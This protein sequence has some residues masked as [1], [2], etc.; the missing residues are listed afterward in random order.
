MWRLHIPWPGEREEVPMPVVGN[1]V[2]L[3]EYRPC[4]AREPVPGRRRRGGQS[5]DCVICTHVV[6]RGHV[7]WEGRSAKMMILPVSLHASRV[8]G[9]LPSSTSSSPHAHTVHDRR[10]MAPVRRKQRNNQ[11]LQQLDHA[12]SL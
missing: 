9:G 10:R 8:A 12:C 5:A 7:L 4:N 3:E 11:K 6:V 2:T 1:V